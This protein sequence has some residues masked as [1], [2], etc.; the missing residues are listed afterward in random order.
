[1]LLG[2]SNSWQNLA[3]GPRPL[4]EGSIWLATIPVVT[5]TVRC[6]RWHSQGASR[7]GRAQLCGSEPYALSSSLGEAGIRS[8]EG[9][10]LKLQLTKVFGDLVSQESHRQRVLLKLGRPA[11]GRLRSAFRAKGRMGFEEIYGSSEEFG[12]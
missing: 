1:M 5:M 9:L 4:V 2:F 6:L 8:P 10:K 7:R 11:P 3:L 12:A